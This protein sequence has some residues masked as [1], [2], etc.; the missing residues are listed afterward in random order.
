M[1]SHITISMPSAPA[2]RMYSRCDMR[3]EL[4]RILGEVVEERLVELRIDQ[5][6]ALA[7][8]LVRHA[9]GAEDH[10]LQVLGIGLDRLADRLAEIEAAVAG[11]RRELHHVDRERDHRARPFLRRAEQQV[12]RH[13]EAVVDLHLVADGEIELVED[14]RLRDV[15]GELAD[16][17]SP[18][19]PG[20]GPSLRRRAGIRRR[21][22]ARR[23]GSSRPRTP[24]RDRCRR[25]CTTSGLAFAHPLLGAAR[26]PRTPASSTA[27]RSGCCRSPRRSPARATTSLLR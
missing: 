18:P 21:S 8:D 16:G 7:A 13:G 4:L 17:P 9:A 12:H 6:G 11:R 14:H 19:A 3:G 5:A 25:R 2:S 26:S 20:A 27:P 22:R 1:M 15:R 23:S 10:D 24:R